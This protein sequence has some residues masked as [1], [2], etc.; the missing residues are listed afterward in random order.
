MNNNSGERAYDLAKSLWPLNR[1]L[2]SKD[3]SKTISVLLSGFEK[4][5][6]VHK[7]RSGLKFGEWEIPKSWEVNAAYIADVS[8]QRVIDWKE[9]NLHL[10]SYSQP[11]NALCTNEE[12]K[13]HLYFDLQTPDWIPYRTSYYENNWGFCVSKRQFD[14]LNDT[15][16]KVFIDSEFIDSELEIGEILI[17]GMSNAE[18]VFT[19][20]ICHPSMANNELSGPVLLNSIASN[21][22]QKKNYY[23]YRFLFMPETIGSIVYINTHLE[24]L[25]KN[26]IAGFVVT[27]VGDPKKWCYISSRNGNTL[28]DRIGLRVLENLSKSY[29]KYTFLDRGSDERQFCSPLV[30]LPFCSI[31]RSKYGTYPEYHTSGDNMDFI[32]ANALQESIEYYWNLIT[33]FELHRVY[34]SN[35]IGEPMYSRHGLRNPIGAQDLDRSSK[36]F[37]DIVAFSDATRDSKEL[38]TLLNVSE[39]IIKLYAEELVIRGILKKY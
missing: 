34:K 3:T 21:L 35:S 24:A 1:T 15:H 31:T 11:F 14:N 17:P 6:K 5:S 10:L 26:V 39:D 8:G 4:Y 38:A 13:K 2:I 22:I 28:A 32:S 9:N 33:E 29:T 25:K 19:T 27:C 7:F 20:Y 12:L 18:I 23:T 36:L 37:S 16:Y 30:D